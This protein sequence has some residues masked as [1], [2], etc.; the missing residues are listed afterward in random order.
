MIIVN[1]FEALILWC[2]LRFF[3]F[4]FHSKQNQKIKKNDEVKQH[5]NISWISSVE[6]SL[7]LLDLV[8]SVDQVQKFLLCFL[9]VFG[10]AQVICS[11][12]A[13]AEEDS[14]NKWS[15]QILPQKVVKL[16]VTEKCLKS[17]Q[18]SSMCWII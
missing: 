10:V 5:I 4:V 3:I 7:I 6:W 2:L 9:Y 11:E 16:W 15:Q 18:H 14:N 12:I 17:L 1:G 8:I 13:N